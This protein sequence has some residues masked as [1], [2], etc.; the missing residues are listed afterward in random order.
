MQA[1]VIWV[2][3]KKTARSGS[4]RVNIR[5]NEYR[6]RATMDLIMYE[7]TRR[8]RF[9][10]SC[11]SLDSKKVKAQRPRSAYAGWPTMHGIGTFWE[12]EVSYS[13]AVDPKT[14]YLMN[15]STIDQAVHDVAICILED[16]LRNRP[17]THPGKVLLK[18]LPALQGSLGESISGVCWKLTPYYWVAIRAKAM[19]RILISQQF[20]FS[21]A[22]RLHIDDLSEEE[23]LKTFG[24]CNNPHSHG[25]NYRIEAV[26]S[27][28]ILCNEDKDLFCVSK[29]E[30][31]VD[32]LI[33]RRFDHT[34]LNLDTT[35]FA[36]LNPTVEHIAKV[37]YDLLTEP[38][39]EAGANLAR[40]TI[41]ETEK[42]SCTYP[43][44]SI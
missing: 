30:R 35:E 32:K 19:D 24:K 3:S 18:V 10:V 21:A 13:G 28:P 23:N 16:A 37:C 29:L 42:S 1:H 7:L 9:C 17:E 36:Q 15:I 11:P 4:V 43:A 25:H 38:I 39:N 41:W 20:E 12:L 44:T 33:I 22:H 14:G 27:A 2:N 8:V 31:I 34:N 26:V 6:I 5:S 40:V